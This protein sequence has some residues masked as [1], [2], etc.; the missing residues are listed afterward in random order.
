M[1]AGGSTVYVMPLGGGEP[2]LVTDSTPS[3][4]H[5]WAPNGRDVLFTAQR[6]GRGPAYNLYKKS[7]DGGPEVQLTFNATGLTDGPEYSPDGNY[8]YYNANQTGTMQVW[9]MKPDGSGQEQLTFDD[10]NSWFP[11]ISPD[12]KWMVILS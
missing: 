11:H 6:T 4:A 2:K 8:I 10:Y 3:Y 1:T 9:R 5:G 12:G 7:I